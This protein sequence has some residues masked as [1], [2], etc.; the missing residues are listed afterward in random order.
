MT[1]L[2]FTSNSHFTPLHTRYMQTYRHTDTCTLVPAFNLF[3]NNSHVL[4]N[5]VLYRCYPLDEHHPSTP[6]IRVRADVGL[7]K[8]RHWDCRLS[9]IQVSQQ[10]E[11]VEVRRSWGGQ[12]W[13]GGRGGDKGGEGEGQG[14]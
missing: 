13:K 14:E 8:R 7:G 10:A 6:V 2:I 3:L 1:L 11:R 12:V 4:H 9:V 5:Q